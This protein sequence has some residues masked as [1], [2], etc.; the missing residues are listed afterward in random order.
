M[1]NSIGK[2]TS[3]ITSVTAELQWANTV[4]YVMLTAEV[5]A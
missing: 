1:G 3:A 2:A 4:G 5:I